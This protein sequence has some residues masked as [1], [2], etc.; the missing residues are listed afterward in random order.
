M[1]SCPIFSSF[2]RDFFPLDDHQ[3]SET[4][5]FFFSGWGGVVVEFKIVNFHHCHNPF[6]AISGSLERPMPQ[7]FKSLLEHP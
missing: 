6:P 2:E 5:F 4:F 1:T 3:N 7:V